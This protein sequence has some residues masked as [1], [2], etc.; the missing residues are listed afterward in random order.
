MAEAPTQQPPDGAFVEAMERAYARGGSRS[1]ARTVD[2]NGA[3][4]VDG[5]TDPSADAW[6]AGL[7]YQPG[8]FPLVWEPSSPDA[9]GSPE[10][11]I[12][13]SM[14]AS[15]SSAA[16]GNTASPLIQAGS[17][18]VPLSAIGQTG[19]A[20]TA[21]SLR[22]AGLSNQASNMAAAAGE[23]VPTA[24][25]RAVAKSPDSTVASAGAAGGAVSAGEARRDTT[26]AVTAVSGKGATLVSA[27][28]VKAALTSAAQAASAGAAVRAAMASEADG[29]SFP[30]ERPSALQTL[31]SVPH[32]GSGAVSETVAVSAPE[33][34]EPSI[35]GYGAGAAQTK[36]ARTVAKAK[37]APSQEAVT[38]Q[39]ASAAGLQAEAVWAANARTDAAPSQQ[40]SA[41]TDAVHG[42]SART[43]AVAA[44]QTS[45]L[46]EA[47]QGMNVRTEAAAA[48]RTGPRSETAMTQHTSAR[49]ET[50]TANQIDAPQEGDPAAGSR[51]ETMTADALPLPE[52]TTLAQADARPFTVAGGTITPQGMTAAQAAN[53]HP[54]AEAANLS[55]SGSADT[56]AAAAKTGAAPEPLSGV[57]GTSPKGT[58]TAC[59]VH[60]QPQDSAAQVAGQSTRTQAAA[61][62][63]N[64]YKGQ[65]LKPE[66]DAE[67]DQ[68]AARSR[69]AGERQQA[70]PGAIPTVGEGP[71]SPP[72]EQAAAL[73]PADG[74]RTSFD[75]DPTAQLAR[76]ALGAVRRGEA[77]FHL[78]LR[79]EGVGEVA[80][81]ISAKDHDL[82]LVI[83]AGSESTRDLILSQIGGLKQD[84]TEGGYRLEGFSVDVSGGQSGQA[85]GARQDPGSQSERRPDVRPEP[86]S[87]APA[88]KEARFPRALETRVGSI[89][90]RI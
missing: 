57:R 5:F 26:D 30:A 23:A 48:L 79:P 56:A 36:A 67:R 49:L 3:C 27:A 61:R 4:G 65:A 69:P 58:D 43:E 19:F 80:V 8:R 87:G 9:A 16:A 37:A 44:M 82:R 64:A 34:P 53:A 40:P 33:T 38:A 11:M 77:Q 90:Y 14:A 28:P 73:A 70:V 89:N 78:K 66:P 42:L 12:L 13:R 76:A 15:F 41:K 39:Q 20:G 22:M 60:A 72:A 85:F 47:V 81:T 1:E 74:Q 35:P 59:A 63:E 83:H 18:E 21:H 88:P 25:G 24:S 31:S 51:P 45:A 86:K 50:V 2:P 6:A 29:A 71:G 32:P 54:G 84:L 75:P 55:A 17:A 52:K 7:N 62:Q 10:G 46:P 68:D